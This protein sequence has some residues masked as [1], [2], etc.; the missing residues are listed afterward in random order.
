MV[1]M[2]F[3]KQIGIFVCCTE[4]PFFCLLVFF[5]GFSDHLLFF[6]FFFSVAPWWYLGSSIDTLYSEKRGAV[7][8]SNETMISGFLLILVAVAVSCEAISSSE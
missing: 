7:I 5:H 1:G 4:F 6:L 3:F 2:I 8:V